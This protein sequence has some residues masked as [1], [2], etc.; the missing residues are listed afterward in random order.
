MKRRLTLVLVVVLLT[1]LV[2]VSFP[3]H[4]QRPDAP[5]YAQRGPFLAGMRDLV[6]EDADR[7]LDITVWYPA[8]HPDDQLES[9]DYIWN[10][11]P[12]WAGEALRDAQPDTSHAPY[13]LVIFSH[14]LGG[15]RF[16][17]AFLMEHLASYGFVVMAADHPGSTLADMLPADLEFNE[18]TLRDLWQGSGEFD[19]E[20]IGTTIDQGTDLVADTFASF[21]LRPFD[22]LRQL[23]YAD[24]LTADGGLLAG[25]IDTEHVAVM[26]HSFGGYTALG[27]GGACLDFD[28]LEDWCRDPEEVIFDPAADPAFSTSSASR[29]LT[30]FSCSVRFAGRQIARERGMRRVPD[31]L[32][33][34]TTDPRIQAVIALAPWNVPAYGPNGL[35][36][37]T[38]PTMIQVGSADSAA[39]P[40]R[41]AYA[42]Y[43]GVGSVDKALVVFDG[44][45]HLIF[46]NSCFGENDPA[47]DMDAAHVLIDHFATAFLLATLYGDADAAAV[48]APEAV[49]F[50]GIDYAS[51]MQN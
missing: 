20:D 48:L 29:S 43:V 51:T 37:L 47:W 4:A 25:V 2:L 1:G 38:V 30:L 9:F 21:A 44:A 14:G 31:G 50:E 19:W 32:W 8:L 26:G 36:T 35:A 41:D 17:S 23:E 28:A 40:G 3:T 5:P 18:D 39:P 6:I 45:D 49:D 15:F 33:P 7:P 22:V 13:P 12:L 24:T 46:I 34:P 10:G 27:S 42:A 11:R 16:Q